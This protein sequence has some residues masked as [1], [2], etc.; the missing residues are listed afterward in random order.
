MLGAGLR[1]GTVLRTSSPFPAIF[2]CPSP[3][4]CS[5]S[6][7]N[8]FDGIFRQFTQHSQGMALSIVSL[9]A[10]L[11]V[12]SPLMPASAVYS[13]RGQRETLNP[14]TA[15]RGLGWLQFCSL[16]FPPS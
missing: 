2:D 11:T 8:S 6:H 7:I 13:E 3:K 15:G 12:D 1:T 14:T 5:S 4:M 10:V 16:P 9:A